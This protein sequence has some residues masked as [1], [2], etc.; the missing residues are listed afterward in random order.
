MTQKLTLISHALCPYVQ[1]VVIVLAEKGISYE[2]KVVD[3][4]KLPDWFKKISPLG[5][6]PVLLVDDEPI[7]ESAVICEY[8][9][10]IHLPRLHPD[11][12]FQ[13]AQ[14]R[15]WMEFGSVLLNAI[16]GFYT[17]LNASLLAEKAMEINAMFKQIEKKLE[18]E[19]YFSGEKFCMVDA[20]FG[21]VFRYFDTFDLID[22]FGF[23]DQ[24]PRVLAWR[25]KLAQRA[26][27]RNAISSDYAALL[28]SFLIDRDSALSKR[29]IFSVNK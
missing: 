22:N 2:R 29:M 24:T 7:F 1:R 10:E 15:A 9:D 11:D 28:R 25:K 14:H 5:K 26:S 3:L 13:R 19:S 17:A 8:L 16:G 18:G 21:P 4:A 27:V 23:F 12:P 6:T 20:M